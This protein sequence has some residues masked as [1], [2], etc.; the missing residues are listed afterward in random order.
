M[1]TLLLNSVDDPVT[2]WENVEDARA[3]IAGNPN[4][5]LAEL[6]RGSHGC[7]FGFLGRQTMAEPIIAEFVIGAWRELQRQATEK[8]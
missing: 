6:R 8:S 4:C 7:K 2:R 5:V 3:E 1:P